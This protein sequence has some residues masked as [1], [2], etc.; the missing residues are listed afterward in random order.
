[1][2]RL[3]VDVL[4]R[5]PRVVLVHGSVTNG[6]ATWG[7]QRA[8]ADRFRLEIVTR[9]GFPPNPPVEP[10]DFELDAPLVARQ[11]D[12]GAHATRP[13]SP[14]S[15]RESA[16]R[17]LRDTGDE[18]S[19]AAHLVGHSYG[20]IVCLLAAALRPD[21]V[22]SLTVIE[23][24]CFGVAAGVP[25]VDEFVA[26]YER[27]VVPVREP[28]ERLE[29]FLGGVGS[30]LRLPDPLPPELEQGARTQMVERGPHE[31]VIPLAA[32]RASS[33]PTL[34]VSGAH[35][36]AF[37]AVC[38]VLERDLGAERMVI[39]G[40]GHA[41]QSVGEPFNEALADFLDRAG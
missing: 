32:L 6:A 38:N 13:V 19:F 31:A 22:R 39:P 5:G 40:G 11:L 18:R 1:V 9:P 15:R 16:E 36:A 12:R 10:I 21:A 3:H 30:A 20:G 14:E 24:S 4:G 7:R 28:R 26:A 17:S 27:D 41:V 29:R 2:R 23:P 34:V 8:L 35:H 37:D 25:A 33:F